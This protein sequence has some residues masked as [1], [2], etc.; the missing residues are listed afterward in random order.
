[1]K[2]TDIYQRVYLVKPITEAVFALY[3]AGVCREITSLYGEKYTVTEGEIP[4]MQV[5]ENA[6]VQG[7]LYCHTGQEAYREAYREAGESAYR[8]IWRDNEKKR[9]KEA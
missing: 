6:L 9:R 7:I 4:L 8:A 5:Y 1:M 2:K 3:L